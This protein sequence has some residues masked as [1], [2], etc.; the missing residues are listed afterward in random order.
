MVMASPTPSGISQ[1]S[2][3]VMTAGNLVA[4]FDVNMTLGVWQQESFGVCGSGSSWTVELY[5]YCDSGAA[6]ITI[7]VGDVSLQ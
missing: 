4:A 5:L 3:R 1:C 7:G 6:T 2:L